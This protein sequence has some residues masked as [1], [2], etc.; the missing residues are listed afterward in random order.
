MFLRK[1]STQFFI[2]KCSKS[3]LLFKNYKRRENVYTAWPQKNKSGNNCAP[4]PTSIKG[5]CDHNTDKSP[6]P[7]GYT[8]LT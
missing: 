8:P 7:K 4:G 5:G 6:N 1:V 2:A 3:S